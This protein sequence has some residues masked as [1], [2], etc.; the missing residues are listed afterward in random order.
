MVRLSSCTGEVYECYSVPTVQHGKARPAD[1][2]SYLGSKGV[3]V[4]SGSDKREKKKK[5]ANNPP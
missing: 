5:L 3:S 1:K 2:N 4:A